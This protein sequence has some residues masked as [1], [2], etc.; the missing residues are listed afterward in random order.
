MNVKLLPMPLVVS[1][2]FLIIWLVLIFLFVLF[3]FLLIVW[4]KSKIL[5]NF[6]TE[7][8]EGNTQKKR[9]AK[10]KQLNLKLAL[11]A[12][13]ILSWCDVRW[14]NNCTLPSVVFESQTHVLC[15]CYSFQ[16]SSYSLIQTITNM[17]KYFVLFSSFISFRSSAF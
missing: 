1:M 5:L 10:K 3:S 11:V 16:L 13:H 7:D 17:L 15:H 8:K 14:G 6:T 4:S 2:M 12:Y 9:N